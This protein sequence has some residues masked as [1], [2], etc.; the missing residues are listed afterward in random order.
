[1][2]IKKLD[3]KSYVDSF[4]SSGDSKDKLNCSDKVSGAVK[5]AYRDAQRTM[6]GIGKNEKKKDDTL[7]K[8]IN[9]IKKYFD[10]KAAPT[11]EEDFDGFHS[12]LC[13]IWYDAFKGSNLGTYGKAQKIVNMTFKYLYCCDDFRTTKEGHFAYCHMPL[14]SYTLEWF[15]RYLSKNPPQ[16]LI[17]S[18]NCNLLFKKGKNDEKYT[19]IKGKIDSWSN[20]ESNSKTYLSEDEKHYAYEFYQTMIRDY[21]AINKLCCS[22]LQ[23]EFIVWPKIQLEMAAESF[24]KSIDYF[25]ENVLPLR[26]ETDKTIC[27][28]LDTIKAFIDKC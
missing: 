11:K 21:I 26:E 20:L 7:S 24:N 12:D 19:I 2:E 23:L 8:L 14:D 9:E 22:P 6:K 5:L 15:K 13:N 3:I 10:K 17:E 16:K 1:M 4:I 27:E 18:D 28:A 25:P